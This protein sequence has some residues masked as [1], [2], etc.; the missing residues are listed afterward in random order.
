M[1]LRTYSYLDCLNLP[2]PLSRWVPESLEA[3][4]PQWEKIDATVF[5]NRSRVL[6]AFR[7]ERVSDADFAES[8]GYGYG[9]QGRDKLE[10]IFARV[11][12]GEAAL[13]RSQMVS[14]THAL[15]I[16]L[17]AL[18]RPGELLLSLTGPPYDTLQTVIGSKG[19]EEGNLAQWGIRYH[20]CQETDRRGYPDLE[21]LDP[22]LNPRLILIQRSPGY[23]PYRP[24]LTISLME[25][26]IAAAR[27]R[28]PEA[29]ILVDNCYG[30]FVEAWEP[31]AA[32]ADLLV[33]SLIKNPGGGLAPGGGYA[34][35]RRELIH[36]VAA[37]MT[38]PGLNAALGP[39]TAKRNLYQGLF[40]APV[41]AGNALK[42]AVFA[43]HLFARMG[44]PVRPAFDQERGDIVQ[45][46]FLKSAEKVRRF[47]QA[48]QK[49]SPVDAHLTLEPA[50]LPGYEDPVIMAAGTFYQG[51]SGELSADAP[52]REPY[53]VFLQGG[54][55]LPHALAA[56]CLAA[57]EVLK[58]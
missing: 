30:E 9:D 25:S 5:I 50:P 17:F 21:G 58:E 40:M 46:I 11:F 19:S 34:V 1:A 4:A 52:M 29:W 43:A 37:R 28:Y 57:A 36:K 22:A 14:G 47:C 16:A 3:V 49:Y 53:A 32:G 24:P 20:Y 12:H 6:E 42:N 26:L 13:V 18:L 8:S 56:T 41:L 44:Y 54:L 48:I 7:Q 35:G 27:R 2:D 10:R 15:C 51:A 31:T 38:A 23:D 55:T 45:T 33:G 39:L